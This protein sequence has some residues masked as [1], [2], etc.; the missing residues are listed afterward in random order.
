MSGRNWTKLESVNGRWKGVR[1]RKNAREGG[2][3]GI[4]KMIMDCNKKSP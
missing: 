4:L 3:R 1:R 2:E